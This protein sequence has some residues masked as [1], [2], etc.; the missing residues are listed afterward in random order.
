VRGVDRCKQWEDFF[1]GMPSKEA[2]VLI[3]YEIDA[4][5]YDGRWFNSIEAWNI[6]ITTW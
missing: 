6:E 4:R 2:P 5:E 1:N 3:K